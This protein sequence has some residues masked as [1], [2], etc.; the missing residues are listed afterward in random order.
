MNKIPVIV[1]AIFGVI[2]FSELIEFPSSLKYAVALQPD[3]WKLEKKKDKTSPPNK[4]AFKLSFST[5][6]KFVSLKSVGGIFAGE[7]TQR[8]LV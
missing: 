6:V 5:F 7:Y 8:F 4:K 2:H 1:T 3:D